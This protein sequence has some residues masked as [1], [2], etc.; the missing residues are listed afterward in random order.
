MYKLKDI[1]LNELKDIP[2]A[3]QKEIIQQTGSPLVLE[4][5]YALIK[6]QTQHFTLDDPMAKEA[7][8]LL[9]ELVEKHRKQTSHRDE[10]Q[11]EAKAIPLLSKEAIRIRENERLR[12]IRLLKIKLT[13][14]PMSA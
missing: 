13:L 1:K 14:K 8:R 12:A 10:I 4:D 7:D 11:Q 3:E 9:F 6:K 2:I 5:G